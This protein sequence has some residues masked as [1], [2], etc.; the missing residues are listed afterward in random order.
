MVKGRVS[1]EPGRAVPVTSAE[2]SVAHGGPSDRS[3]GEQLDEEAV[4][5]D[6]GTFTRHPGELQNG[7]QG[8]QSH[9][10]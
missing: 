8:S 7:Q 2:R 5:R 6:L 9:H 4:R 1:A 3:D 10:D